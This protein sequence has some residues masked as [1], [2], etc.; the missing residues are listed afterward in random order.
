MITVRSSSR[1]FSIAPACARASRAIRCRP[2]RGPR[3]PI[4]AAPICSGKR[5][6]GEPSTGGSHSRRRRRRPRRG[7]ATAAPS[8]QGSGF[9][10]ATPSMTYAHR[11]RRGPNQLHRVF[12][13]SLLELKLS[14]AST[15]ARARAAVCVRAHVSSRACVAHANAH[16]R[17]LGPFMPSEARALLRW[18][19]LIFFCLSPPPFA[20]PPHS[21][22]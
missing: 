20:P 18:W 14:A 11:A 17:S 10:K 16:A 12:C 1:P 2:S 4:G 6:T 22:K 9:A 7:G 8:W 5:F 15:V 13:E 3:E 19:Q 21:N